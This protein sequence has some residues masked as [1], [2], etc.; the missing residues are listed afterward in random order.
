M[1]P[2]KPSLL[3]KLELETLPTPL[4]LI[5]KSIILCLLPL[6]CKTQG[7]STP[8]IYYHS[9]SILTG[10][11]LIKI[12]VLSFGGAYHSKTGSFIF[13]GTSYVSNSLSSVRALSSDGSL[14]AAIQNIALYSSSIAIDSLTDTAV[15]PG[16]NNG[17][18]MLSLATTPGG[19]PFFTQ[20]AMEAQ[21]NNLNLYTVILESST[22][23]LYFSTKSGGKVYRFNKIGFAKTTCPRMNQDFPFNIAFLKPGIILVWSR[24]DASMT[25]LDKT[26]MTWSLADSYPSRPYAVLTDPSLPSGPT[27]ISA[28]NSGASGWFSLDRV[29]IGPPAIQTLATLLL[30]KRAN[31]LLSIGTLDY[32]VVGIDDPALYLFIK[33]NFI[34]VGDPLPTA[35]QA[36]YQSLVGVH[37]LDER[38]VFSV[39]GGGEVYY[40][41]FKMSFC[42][43]PGEV[44]CTVCQNS[45]YLTATDTC[46]LKTQFPASYG[47]DSFRVVQC[48]DAHCSNCTDNYLVCRQC[49]TSA[50][51]FL[52]SDVCVEKTQIKKGLGANLSA[53]I[54]SLCADLDC[55]DCRLD[56]TQCAWCRTGYSLSLPSGGVCLL[57][58]G[59]PAGKGPN[60][61]TGIMENCVQA[62]C[63]ECKTDHNTC[64]FCLSGFSIYT[65][66]ATSSNQCMDNSLILD[67]FGPNLATGRISGCN[68]ANCNKCKSDHLVCTYCIYMYALEN[69]KCIKFDQIEDYRG[70]NLAT[71]GI[72]VCSSGNC[73]KCKNDRL[74]CQYCDLG[75]G[76]LYNDCLVIDSLKDGYGFNKEVGTVNFCSDPQCGDCRADIHVCKRCFDEHFFSANGSCLFYLSIPDRL[77]ANRDTLKVDRC[78]VSNCLYCKYDILNCTMCIDGFEMGEGAC[79]VIVHRIG[80][81]FQDAAERGRRFDSDISLFMGFNDTWLA[82]RGDYYEKTKAIQD[83]IFHFEL[84]D[85]QTGELEKVRNLRYR[86]SVFDTAYDTF[87]LL[88]VYLDKKLLGQSYEFRVHLD[89]VIEFELRGE[90][91][92]YDLFNQ[93]FEYSN[94]KPG[95]AVAYYSS[96]ARNMR[97][98][99]LDPSPEYKWIYIGSLVKFILVYA[100]PSG[101]FVRFLHASQRIQKMSQMNIN[102]GVKLDSFLSI[103]NEYESFSTQKVFDKK[104]IK[105]LRAFRGKVT[106]LE[107]QFFELMVYKVI[108]Y[109]LSWFLF[110]VASITRHFDAIIPEWIIRLLFWH[111]KFHQ[112]VFNF[113]MMDLIS[114]SFRVAT[115][116]SAPFQSVL[117]SVCLV[118]VSADIIRILDVMW[119][120]WKWLYRLKMIRLEESARHMSTRSNVEVEE[121]DIIDKRKKRL[122]SQYRTKFDAVN[123]EDLKGYYLNRYSTFEKLD[124]EGYKVRFLEAHLKQERRVQGVL[125]VRLHDTVHYSRMVGFQLIVYLAPYATAPGI[126]SLC[127]LEGLI[128]ACIVSLSTKMKGYLRNGM[129]LAAEMVRSV[130]MGVI[131]YFIFRMK[132]RYKGEVDTVDDL[133]VFYLVFGLIGFEV[134]HMGI[135]L[136]LYLVKRRPEVGG[137][138]AYDQYVWKLKDNEEG[139]FREEG[140]LPQVNTAALDSNNEYGLR[141]SYKS[142]QKVRDALGVITLE[143]KEEKSKPIILRGLSRKEEVISEKSRRESIE[144]G[145]E[146][147]FVGLDFGV[148]KSGQK[149]SVSRTIHRKKWA[150]MQT[151][152]PNDL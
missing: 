131:L 83:R 138:I 31:S 43:N 123:K 126:L 76:L 117:G 62:N 7:T 130:L 113:L 69:N 70:A 152:G 101:I 71:G 29:L 132:D 60:L 107:P 104:E 150:K 36:N 72:D 125:F 12:N 56:N 64:L 124:S 8:V 94:N 142:V 103:L 100:D 133:M 49:D 148:E 66:T 106:N 97:I 88:Q 122:R 86:T 96:I 92:G 73:L 26:T 116:G 14:I 137:D 53:G 27:F 20:L 48:K 80:V 77:G 115:S 46:I 1:N 55:E 135:Q 35:I 32:L 10:V 6:F 42:S 147:I 151:E 2:S 75:Y 21:G 120:S 112:A 41:Y 40:Y 149:V 74:L 58:T 28:Y 50:G 139:M 37:S 128:V 129:V 19:T 89:E 39:I 47:V 109:L 3:S 134:V 33:S 84:R 44:P 38:S 118:L 4:S 61:V 25:V 98:V 15:V 99:L 143:G 45:Y 18:N 67:A 65:S 68:V 5:L 52:F 16:L 78:V 95:E 136:S 145:E 34:Q 102:Y 146:K 90:M 85:S 121:M 144:L 111:E 105:Y 30:V 119:N 82:R 22:T 81:S 108:L 9:P 87:I 110:M 59:L 11:P 23:Y 54:V 91:F 13:P 140:S 57:N 79:K 127:V 141:I 93:T 63:K 17:I 114:F 24:F 51:Y